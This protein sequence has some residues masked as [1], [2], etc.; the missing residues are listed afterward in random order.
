HFTDSIERMER[1]YDNWKAG[2]WSADPFLDMMIP[3]T[4]DPTM[5]PP[6]WVPPMS[7]RTSIPGRRCRR[8]LTVVSTV[9]LICA[10]GSRLD[11]RR[12]WRP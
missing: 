8:C 12:C 11:S 4:L 3:T 1:A 7:T 10:V 6:W 2:R 9:P 5:A